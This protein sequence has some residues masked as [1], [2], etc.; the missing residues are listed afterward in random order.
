M[1]KEQQFSA[2]SMLYHSHAD[3][4]LGVFTPAR[5]A[6]VLQEELRAQKERQNQEKERQ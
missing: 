5:R 6:E 2:Y 3:S 1:P 4:G